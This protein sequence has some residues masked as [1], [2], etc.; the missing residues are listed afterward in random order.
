LEALDLSRSVGRVANYCRGKVSW[1][2]EYYGRLLRS[3]AQWVGFAGQSL[4]FN[5]YLAA[6]DM[7]F[8]HPGA[9]HGLVSRGV[10]NFWAALGTCG[11]Y[12]SG[13]DEVFKKLGLLA[14]NSIPGVIAAC[15]AD[16][17]YGFIL[18]FPG[19]V[20]NYKLSGCEWLTSIVL[21]A[22]ASVACCWTSSIS[23]ALFDT[24]RALDSDDPQHKV[25]AP[26]WIQW[27]VI[28]RIELRTRKKLIWASLVGSVVATAAI[29][30][31][32]PG[33]LLK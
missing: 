6:A 18:N 12:S 32:A 24:F 10:A 15:L 9:L 14:P 30:C 31:F 8:V 19:F 4:F 13:R 11:I 7:F 2:A 33:G 1:L 16:T 26:A 29:Y 27:A 22:K 21:G 28:D 25:R 23:G 17:G 3:R 20:L 5:P